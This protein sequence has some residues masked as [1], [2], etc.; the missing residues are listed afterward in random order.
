MIKKQPFHFTSLRAA[1][2]DGLNPAA[3]MDEALRRVDAAGDPGIFLHLRDRAALLADVD[4]LGAFDPVSKPLWGIP[5]AIKDNIDA[6]GAPTTAACPAY[7][8]EAVRDAF[9]VDL[10]RRAGA[11]LIGK[12]N[13]D[14]FATGLVGTRT[15]YPVP[16]NALDPAIVPADPVADRRWRWRAVW[17]ASR[18]AP[19]RP[20]RAGC[21][22]R[23]MALLG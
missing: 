13:L 17:W 22:P 15:P 11:I 14:Q 16:R 1:Y 19:I 3:V 2:A 8:Y 12:T 18:L 6:A 23:S 7:A 10:L 4:E 20:V 9:V 21:R 5:F